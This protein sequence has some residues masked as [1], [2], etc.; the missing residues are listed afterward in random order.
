MCPG[1][2]QP[3]RRAPLPPAAAHGCRAPR[4]VGPSLLWVTVA[5]RSLPG[6]PPA[7]SGGHGD[8]PGP[9]PGAARQTWSWSVIPFQ[10]GAAG[11]SSPD[12]GNHHAATPR[13]AATRRTWAGEPGGP[14][15][16]GA[17]GSWAATWGCGG[18]PVRP[19]ADAEGSGDKARSLPGS[20]TRR[21]AGVLVCT[22]SF[23][24]VVLS[25]LGFNRAP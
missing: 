16:R 21:P 8:G 5:A 14:G 25:E 22:S 10:A 18:L 7:G 12:A 6:A 23:N 24:L 19:G 9:G 13:G 4:R 17:C 20:Q 15:P 2:G 11:L 1:E 3:A